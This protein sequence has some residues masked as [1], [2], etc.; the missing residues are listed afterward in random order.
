MMWLPAKECQGV[1]AASGAAR[2]ARDRSSP[3]VSRRSP[4]CQH[5]VLG[6]FASRT[7]CFSATSRLWFS[8]M[9]A[10]GNEG[11]PSLAGHPPLP[12]VPSIPTSQ[13]LGSQPLRNSHFPTSVCA[14]PH[15]PASGKP[16]LTTPTHRP[17]PP[18][19]PGL[20]PDSGLFVL[21]A[22]GPVAV[23]WAVLATAALTSRHG[24][25]VTFS[26]IRL[27]EPPNNREPRSKQMAAPGLAEAWHCFP[28]SQRR[29]GGGKPGSPSLQ[30]LPRPGVCRVGG[31]CLPPR[32][33]GCSPPG[34]GSC[35]S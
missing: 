2:E 15:P 11:A 26:F 10:P 9:A 16:A 18:T 17:R 34:P 33:P 24:L 22:A 3:R 35:G 28:V 20:P 25:P 5:L 12:M 32:G 31:G 19:R 7:L 29:S 23:P 4:P 14:P 27:S 1:P 6:L 30:G 13:T 21:R 8:G